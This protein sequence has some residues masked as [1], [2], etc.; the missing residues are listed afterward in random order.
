MS[1]DEFRE[2]YARHVGHVVSGDMKAAI[3]EMVPENIPAVFEGVDVPREAVD[4]HRIVDV[5]AE[6]DK[7]VGETV[8]QTKKGPI[9]L[10]SIWESRDGEWLAAD[11]ENFA[12]EDTDE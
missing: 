1:L 10:R 4:G 12:P 5:R 2:R 11:L 6:G 9:G 8:Y 3:A 7:M